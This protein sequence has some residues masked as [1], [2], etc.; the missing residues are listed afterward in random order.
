MR[1]ALLLL[2][3]IA[4]TIA[5]AGTT[6]DAA[7][8]QIEPPG[9]GTIRAAY[10]DL[11][12]LSYVHPQ[13]V[14]LLNAA[15]TGIA[16]ALLPGEP[17]PPPLGPLPQEASAAFD[18]F[19]TAYANYIQNY[20]KATVRGGSPEA[21]ALAAAGAMAQATGEPH[22]H[23]I[24]GDLT[25]LT[26]GA[27]LGLG[28]QA[29]TRPPVIVTD[30]A[31][32]SP[33]Q[34]AG[35]QPGDE[36]LAVDGQPPASASDL[37]PPLST[38][39]GNP[40]TLT[41][42]R[43]GQ[44]Q[45]VRLTPS[46]FNFPLLTSRLL[47]GGIAYLRINDFGVNNAYF[48]NLTRFTTELDQRLD[49]FDTH[50]ARALVLDLRD[51]GSN[52]LAAVAA[53]LGRFLPEG[54]LTIREFTESGQ[55][56]FG[57]VS[58]TMRARQLPIVVLIDNGT[59]AAA[60][61]A[62]GVLQ[63]T[64]RALLV[65]EKSAGSLAATRVIPISENGAL[66]I[67]LARATL[68]IGDRAIDGVGLTPDLAAPDTRTGDDVRAGRDP[69]LDAA[70]QATTRAPA[71]PAPATTASP[72]TIVAVHRLL[73]GYV[74][75]LTGLLMPDGVAALLEPLDAA[76]IASPSE[77]A[78][79]G[80]ADPAALVAALRA[81]GWLGRHAQ[82]FN[83]IVDGIQPEL[84]VTID[85]YATPE[86][87]AAALRE[88]PFPAVQQLVTPPVTLGEATVA[89]SGRW[90]RSGWTSLSWQRANV[91]ATV[92]Y[93]APPGAGGR[94]TA[95]LTGAAAKIDEVL[96]RYPVTSETFQANLR[97]LAAATPSAPQA[98]TATAPANA[99]RPASA[100]ATATSAPAPVQSQ[101]ALAEA[102]APAHHGS[103]LSTNLV[104]TV[105]AVLALLAMGGY[106]LRRA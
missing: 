82:T 86:G 92:T 52:D 30:V 61:V 81:R 40:L 10:D 8:A 43:N 44:Q 18:A 83:V 98:T 96:K 80:L 62:A 9:L 37:A 48:D 45:Q 76:D 27:Q 35:L 89:Y 20:Q 71:P 74:P 42:R 15:W 99:Q 14:A 68:A 84:V 4:C 63:A 49:D 31:P 72:A 28:I 73:A 47:S 6:R 21:L 106:V 85:A 57:A 95:M 39:R 22:T 7:R 56:A 58:G 93:A 12:G 77:L 103:W 50:N 25:D 55:Q 24:I 65:G 94:T 100:A 60:E 64:G 101:S 33:A 5:A 1:R 104:L 11:L 16:A 38:V 53:L 26:G 54:T 91:V 3:S 70:A 2:L 87:A 67:G 36:I 17:V 90:L 78:T 51:N 29:R 34:R 66:Q 23:L 69:A 13:P 41:I 75:A 102:A 46:G 32:N 105:L 59:S 88:N 19:A 79:A 97:A